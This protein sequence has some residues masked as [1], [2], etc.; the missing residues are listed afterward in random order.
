MFDFIRKRISGRK[1]FLVDLLGPDESD[2]L[3]V[4]GG[5]PPGTGNGL[6]Q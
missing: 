5:T 1:R 4:D 3:A 2:D 6:P